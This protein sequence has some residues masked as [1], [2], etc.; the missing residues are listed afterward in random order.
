LSVIAIAL[1]WI[2]SKIEDDY[3]IER[4]GDIYKEHMARVPRWNV[5][6]GLRKG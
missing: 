2:A 1:L 5:F 6:N 3:N 4:F